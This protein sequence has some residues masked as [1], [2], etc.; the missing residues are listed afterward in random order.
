MRR[1]FRMQLSFIRIYNG[2]VWNMKNDTKREWTV[3][4]I[5][6]LISSVFGLAGFLV[7]RSA[8]GKT[9]SR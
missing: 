5:L 4:A 6:L 2:G 1:I 9:I 7:G 8:Y 3:M